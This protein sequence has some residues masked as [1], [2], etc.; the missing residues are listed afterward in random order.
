MIQAG[1]VFV[2][3]DFPILVKILDYH[4]ALDK[5]LTLAHN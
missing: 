3:P 2:N 5:W 1:F 4:F